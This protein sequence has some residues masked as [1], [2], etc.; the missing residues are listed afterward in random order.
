MSIQDD[1]IGQLV[2]MAAASRSGD[3]NSIRADRS[4][5]VPILREALGAWN[6]PNPFRPGDII[7]VA[8]HS[9]LWKTSMGY[10]IVV[11]STSE[12][13][14]FDENV[15]QSYNMRILALQDTGAAVEYRAHSR[16]FDLV[17]AA[18]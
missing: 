9:A 7:R 17:E 5:A 10:A 6:N 11:C 16:D 12:H 8:K 3:D 18:P 4:R 15:V 14:E 13:V 2:A 1:V